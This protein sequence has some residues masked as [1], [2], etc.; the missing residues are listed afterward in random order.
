MAR[1]VF[2]RRS[3]ALLA[4][5]PLFIGAAA[6]AAE[7]TTAAAGVMP[8]ATATGGGLTARLEVR[9]LRAD[10]TAIRA[11]EPALFRLD[12]TTGEEGA[13]AGATPARGLKP[14]AWAERGARAS[15]CRERM[16]GLLEA[17][18][19]RRAELD[20]NAWHLAY[21]GDNGALYVLDPV[22]GTQRSRLLTAV[23]LGAQVG[24]LAEDPARDTLYVSLP[25]EGEVLEIDTLRWTPRRRIAVGGRPARLLLDADG[26]RLW[27][28]QDGAEGAT[29]EVAMVD[30]AGGTVTARLAAPAGTGPQVLAAAGPGRVVVGAP[31]GAALLDATRAAPGQEPVASQPLPGLGGGFADA[32]WSPLAELALLLDPAEGRVL[33][34]RP[35]DGRPVAT[36]P[37]SPGAAGLFPDPSG[38]LLFVPEPGEGRVA[39]IDLGRGVVA[40]RVPIEGA[41]PL[42]VGFSGTQAYVQSAAGAR[43]ALI[44]LNSLLESGRPAVATIAAG[45]GGLRPGEVVGPTVRA[46]PGEDAMLIAA[47]EE[48]AIHVYQEG[49]AGPSGLLRAPR[50]RPLAILTADRGLRETAPGRYEAQA[51][52]PG[53][54]RYVVPVMVQGGGFLHCFEL[55][56]MGD[57][58]P[59]PLSARLGLE[60]EGGAEDRVLRAASPAP[61]RLR[62][63]G[64]AEEPAWR[65]ARDVTARLVQFEGHWQTRLRLRALGDGLYE[66]ASAV[67]PPRPG[68][69]NLYVE[70]PSLGLEPGTLPYIALRAEGP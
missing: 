4:L 65:E 60:F 20:L 53:P 13:A 23:N 43:V 28:G 2:P 67:T 5:L 36:W 45:E 22:G 40:H 42:R 39:V 26:L 27:V 8:A 32:A 48:R 9:P 18:F 11:G 66:A 38:R 29:A 70:S 41:A 33:A 37:V 56:V 58:R 57:G 69:V 51:I 3:A 1:G 50:G 54:G 63:R 55:D 31:D 17:R 16:R 64:P 19:G 49:M 24:G 35:G 21:V 15:S 7:E 12:F 14:A 62:L 25:A 10:A 68:P 46:A 34:L 52:F 6:A 44:A 59:P 47:P 61:L 30:R